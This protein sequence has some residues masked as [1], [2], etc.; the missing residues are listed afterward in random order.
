MIDTVVISV[1]RTMHRRYDQRVTIS[2]KQPCL[3]LLRSPSTRPEAHPEEFLYDVVDQPRRGKVQDA[4]YPIGACVDEPFDQQASLDR[5]T[6]PYLVG[7][8]HAPK[9]WLLED[10]LDQRRLVRERLDWLDIKQSM[11]VFEE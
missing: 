5:L 6:Q 1:D 3:L 11:T 8:E 9:R 2:G 4:W 7:D 10:V